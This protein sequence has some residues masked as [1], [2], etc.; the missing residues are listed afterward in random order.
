[1]IYDQAS[2]VVIHLQGAA[3]KAARRET[4][5]TK[6]W[7]AAFRFKGPHFKATD[8]TTICVAVGASTV[9]V[10][11]ATAEAA[12]EYIYPLASVGRIKTIAN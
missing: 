12:G 5:K 7:L 1:M 3:L 10:G 8:K 9:N 11:W 6:G 4:R 2:E